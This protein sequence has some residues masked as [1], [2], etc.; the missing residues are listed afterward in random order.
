MKQR[1]YSITK[2]DADLIIV[3]LSVII[4]ELNACR[5]E[6]T[7]REL[8]QLCATESLLHKLTTY[9]WEVER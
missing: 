4:R 1:R 8:N 5:N 6:L 7:V 2:N 3:A 9:Q